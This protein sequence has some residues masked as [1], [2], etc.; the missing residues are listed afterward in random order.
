V[1]KPPKILERRAK[2]K[3]AMRNVRD[4]GSTAAGQYNDNN[5]QVSG[6]RREQDQG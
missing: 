1:S 5:I 4:T 2:E 6:R 3:K